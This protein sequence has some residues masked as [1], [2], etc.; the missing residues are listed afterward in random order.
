[1]QL[2]VRLLFISLFF[3]FLPTLVIATPVLPQHLAVPG[4]IAVV[5]L[6]ATSRP[7]V[8]F[9]DKRVLVVENEG[10]W[11]AVLGIPLAATPGTYQLRVDPGTAAASQI[12]VVV[13]AK[14]YKTQHLT[15][16][17][18]RKV[19]PNKEDL[20]R[21]EHETREIRAALASWHDAAPATFQ[22]QLP[23]EAPL[24]STFGLRRFFNGQPRKPHSGMDLAAATGTPIKAPAPGKV[25]TTG[26]YFFNGKTVFLD[27]GQG[28]ISMYCHLNRID[29]KTGQVLTQG[30]VIGTV[31]QT[32]RATGP[33]LHWGV[34]LNGAFVDPSLLL[35]P[36]IA[37]KKK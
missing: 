34:I 25:I 19:E 9:E 5:P 16:K 35:V 29:V 28:L 27:H 6:A 12:D 36:G 22:F 31:G 30:A 32:G 4:G 10:K 23:L 1:M 24:S 37:D 8:Y 18:K 2:N 21:I 7:A 13:T 33:H 15:L 17:D 3:L 14:E 20:R 11:W 26:D